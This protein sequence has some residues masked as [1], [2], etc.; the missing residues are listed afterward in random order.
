MKYII[1]EIGG[2]QNIIKYQNWYDINYI[3]RIN[4]QKYITLEKILAIR[5]IDSVQI[6]KP[7]LKN[8]YISALV[9]SDNLSKKIKIF[10]YKPKKHYSKLKGYRNKNTR[11]FINNL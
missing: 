5:G 3:K 9:L 10:K 1:T 11:I 2:K 4:I 6:G 8:S 7:F